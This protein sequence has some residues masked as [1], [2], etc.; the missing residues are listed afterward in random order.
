MRREQQ[1]CPDKPADRWTVAVW[2][3]RALDGDSPPPPVAQS[4]FADVDDDE[5]WMPYVERLADLRITFGCKT[6]PLNFCPDETVTRAITDYTIE[7]RQ[8]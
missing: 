2:I 1:F 3:V 7:C 6:Q 5:W 4:R 8:V